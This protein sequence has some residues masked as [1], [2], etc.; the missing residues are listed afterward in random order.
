LLA[1]GDISAKHN[2]QKA[3]GGS[4]SFGSDFSISKLLAVIQ[5]FGFAA[6]AQQAKMP[7]FHK[8]FRQ[9]VHQESAYELR[10]GNGH[11][12][13]S[14]IIFV[15][16]PFESD[17]PIIDVEYAVVGNGNAVSIAA[18]VFNDGG[19]R[20]EGWFTVDDPAFAVTARNKVLEMNRVCQ[21][22]LP[23]KEIKV[24]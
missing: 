13:P 24:L 12:L 1:D 8:A 17:L 14:V 15:I 9:D 16:A 6:V 2:V 23:L 21:I 11:I 20:F 5:P 4:L 10:C 19:S 22:A 7:Y 18:K 3:E